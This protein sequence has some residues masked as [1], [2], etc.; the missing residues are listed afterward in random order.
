MYYSKKKNKFQHIRDVEIIRIYNSEYTTG[1]GY[2]NDLSCR[3]ESVRGTVFT[4]YER[5]DI[6]S[7]RKI[8]CFR[9]SYM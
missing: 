1:D 3:F 2:A 8:L 9:E 7:Q 5:D 4:P 6:F